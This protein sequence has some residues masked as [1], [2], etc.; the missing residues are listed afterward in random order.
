[1]MP[2]GIE[3]EKPE[4]NEERGFGGYLFTGTI[5]F[6]MAQPG[7]TDT[8]IESQRLAATSRR[9]DRPTSPELKRIPDE[10]DATDAILRK[11]KVASVCLKCELVSLTSSLPVAGY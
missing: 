6:V 11:A 5:M 3:V 4:N 7:A 8:L 9:C 10:V 1:M 2:F